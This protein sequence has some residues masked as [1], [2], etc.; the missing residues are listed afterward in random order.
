MSKQSSIYLDDDTKRKM[1]IIVAMNPERWKNVS[2][3]IREACEE[4]L[5]KEGEK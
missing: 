3:F 2:D 1:K 4:K 5:Q